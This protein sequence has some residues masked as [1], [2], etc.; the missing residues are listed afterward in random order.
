VEALAGMVELARLFGLSRQRIQQ[1]AVRRG[2]PEPLA[3]LE[4][5]KVWWLP[6][7]L[8]WAIRTNRS[9]PGLSDHAVAT[10]PL[11]RRAVVGAAELARQ[12]GVSRQRVQ[13]IA[14]KSGF[15][16][17]AATLTM[18]RLWYEDECHAWDRMR[19]SGTATS[20]QAPSRD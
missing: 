8:D 14:A 20:N 12:F 5:G 15:P 16:R 9:T 3:S 11:D 7:V 4:M 17:P 18:G 6:E 19:K 1:L 10:E 13:Q 2:F